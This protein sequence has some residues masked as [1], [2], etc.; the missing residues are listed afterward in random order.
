MVNSRKNN[1]YIKL[2]IDVPL[3]DAIDIFKEDLK[4]LKQHCIKRKQ[5]D[6]YRKMKASLTKEDTI[7]HTDFAESYRRMQYKVRILEIKVSVI[8]QL[9][10]T[11]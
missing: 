8:S 7:G 4:R 10:E 2:K 11:C 1:R 6:G 3:Y 5:F 9:Y